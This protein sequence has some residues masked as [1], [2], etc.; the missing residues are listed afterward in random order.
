MTQEQFDQ[1]IFEA[2]YERALAGRD[3]G[4]RTDYLRAVLKVHQLR[5]AQAAS[6]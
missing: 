4:T 6:A 5:Q 2:S 3:D 1:A